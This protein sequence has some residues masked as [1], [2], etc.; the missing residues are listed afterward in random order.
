MPKIKPTI[1]YTSRDFT[2]IRKDLVQY[3]KRYYPTTYKDFSEASFGSLMIDTVSYVGDIL[4]F[5]LDYQTNESFLDTAIEYN[6]VLRLGQQMGYKFKR[7]HSSFGEVACYVVVPASSEGLGPD[8][9][10]LPVLRRGSTFGTNKG[11]LYT[12]LDDINFNLP[13][14][15]I[16]VASVNKTTGVPINYAIKAYGRV[17]SG[18]TFITS[19][20]VGSHEK[21]KK[22]KVNARN[23]TEI[24]SVF[25]SEGHEYFQV[26]FLSQ[27]VVYKEVVNKNSDL[28][29]VANILK[30]VVVPR[31]FV[32][33][34]E[35]DEVFLQFGFGS[36]GTLSDNPL[37]DPTSM[38]L[39]LHGRDYI[40]DTSFDPSRLV[41]TD[42]LGIVP[43]NTTLRIM[44]RTNSDSNANAA[45]GTVS[46]VIKSDFRFQNR[47][48]LNRI[49]INNVI[50]SLE[51]EN[52][53]PIVGDVSVPSVQE[54]KTRIHDVFAAQNRAV[55]REDYKAT[56]YSMPSKF[57]AIKRCNIIQDKNSFKRNLNL[58]IISNLRNGQLTTA[59][60]SLKE[61]LKV[62]LNKKRIINDTIDILDAKIINIGIDFEIIANIDFDKYV[63]LNN[64][65]SALRR[66]FSTKM[67]IGENLPLTEIFNQ[68]NKIEGVSDAVDVRVRNIT[69]TGYSGVS[70]NIENFTSADE[71]FVYCPENVI[72]EVKR[73]NIDIK[74]VVR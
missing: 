34:Q 71:R 61:N 31:R 22:I 2:S 33:V 51:I 21:F 46:Q 54:V 18:Q 16:V 35:R 53:E 59:T 56:V 7:T 29:Q 49:K 47:S 23:I 30:P 69:T 19:V 66:Y 5:Y 11:S 68:L 39:D 24:I 64:A 43:A 67:D 62:W 41:Q 50:G 17:M 60:N 28:S 58:Y 32:T 55:T 36:E 6:N 72:F 63:V 3:A 37:I 14:N 27:N 8:T 70:Y 40:S 1:K 25:D 15:E 9:N 20:A 13:E 44:Y 10:Y 52:E 4:S 45:A 12:L 38:I 65:I 74:G 48:L 42:K 26:D 73:P 57:G